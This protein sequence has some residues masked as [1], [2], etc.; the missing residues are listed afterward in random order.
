MSKLRTPTPTPARRK[1]PRLAVLAALHHDGLVGRLPDPLA[2]AER[3]R[4]GPA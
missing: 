1:R 4:V 2:E 3:D